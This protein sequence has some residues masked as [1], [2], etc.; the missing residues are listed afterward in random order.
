M[1]KNDLFS[2]QTAGQQV[3]LVHQE[4]HC[5]AAPFPGTT[6]AAPTCQ[7]QCMIGISRFLLENL[8][9]SKIQNKK[10]S[11]EQDTNGGNNCVAEY[12]RRKKIEH[13]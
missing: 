2:V 8:E 6:C 5:S 1:L 13:N 11:H 7:P 9:V 4:R 10:I 12:Q 3:T